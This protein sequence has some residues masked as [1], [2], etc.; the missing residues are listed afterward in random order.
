MVG[1]IAAVAP[2][3]EYSDEI[4]VEYSPMSGEPQPLLLNDYER[5]Y[6]DLST[7]EMSSLIGGFM[8]ATAFPN[9]DAVR[10]KGSTAYL[11]DLRSPV[12]IHLDDLAFEAAPQAE[13]SKP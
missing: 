11:A 9:V 3:I 13:G 10:E 6:I 1:G 4:G 7:S 2:N 12:L 8:W 5:F